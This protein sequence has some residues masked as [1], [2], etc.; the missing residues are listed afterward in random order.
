M[1][2]KTKKKIEVQTKVNVLCDVCGKDV[3]HGNFR[4]Y[5]LDNVIQLRA[6][7]GECYPESD[8]RITYVLDVCGPCFMSKIKPAI[9]S[10]AAFR[11]FDTEDE[12]PFLTD[13]EATQ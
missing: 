11:E 5:V 8:C 12:E 2:V 4:N 13:G 10:V 1:T 3:D 6:A 7:I 9:E